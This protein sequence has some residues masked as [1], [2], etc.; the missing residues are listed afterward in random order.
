MGKYLFLLKSG[1][2]LLINKN[3]TEKIKGLLQFKLGRSISLLKLEYEDGEI[4]LYGN[5]DSWVCREKAIILCGN[6]KGVSS[7]NDDYLYSPDSDYKSELYT[8][9][10]DETLSDIARLY[11][12][13]SLKFMVIYEAN[14]EILD[15][16]VDVYPGLTIRIPMLGLRDVAGMRMKNKVNVFKNSTC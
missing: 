15:G 3:G 14:R 1:K 12:Q 11:Y 16:P 13:D 5:C 9:K 8:I 7:V 4:V 10:N 6:V 2:N